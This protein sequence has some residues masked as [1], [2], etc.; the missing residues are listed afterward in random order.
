MNTT[1]VHYSGWNNCLRIANSDIELVA[2]LDVGPRI[3]RFGFCGEQNEFA[4]YSEQIGLSG[5]RS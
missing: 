5:D 1:P 4:E 3:I 2:T